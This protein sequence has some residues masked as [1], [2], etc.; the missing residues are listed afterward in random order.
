VVE[1]PDSGMVVKFD[2][3]PDFLFEDVNTSTKNFIKFLI[4]YFRRTGI[5][6]TSSDL[7][8][9][10]EKRMF[11]AKKLKS[12]NLADFVIVSYDDFPLQF[13]RGTN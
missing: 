9:R 11:Q 8:V 1:G 12:E 2:V 6:R 10:K 7:S 4:R 3:E 5:D 13:V